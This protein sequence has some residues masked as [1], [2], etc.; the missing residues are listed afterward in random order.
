MRHWNKGL[1]SDLPS[2]LAEV[3]GVQGGREERAHSNAVI[4]IFVRPRDE[5][6]IY[7]Q[8]CYFWDGGDF[9]FTATFRHN[10]EVRILKE[11]QIIIKALVL[12]IQMSK[13]HTSTCATIYCSDADSSHCSGSTHGGWVAE[14][15]KAATIFQRQ[16]YPV[17]VHLCLIKGKLAPII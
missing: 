12:F 4:K 11:S 1:P 10:K 6:L 15:R 2:D 14:R 17:Q 7:G 8:E 16:Q 3:E 13:P 5:E 9:S